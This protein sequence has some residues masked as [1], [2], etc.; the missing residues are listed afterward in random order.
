MKKVQKTMVLVLCVALIAGVFSC[1][2]TGGGGGQVVSGTWTWTPYTLG[3]KDNGDTSFCNLREADEEIG[4][5]TVHTYILSG[6]V[7]MSIQYGLAEC[8][9][10]PDAETLELLKTCKAISFKILGDGR[11][12]NIEVPI[13]TVRNW[14]FH[15]Q[16]IATT[17]GEVED[18]FLPMAAFMQP[19]W[20]DQP[21]PFNRNLIEK[22]IF[23]TK[24]N[25]EG[26]LG[27]FSVKIWDLQLHM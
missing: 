2:S 8:D 13:T 11:R 6:E 22:I 10:V 16:S 20:N 19:S 18:I 1:T 4:G 17:E 15:V 24:N 25:A 14:A 12:Y 3:T 23:K 27:N 9:I 7:N 5:A 21:R 26:G